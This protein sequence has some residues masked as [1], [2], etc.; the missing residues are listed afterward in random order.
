[1]TVAEV[2]QSHGERCYVVFSDGSIVKT[3]LNVILE[4]HVK[5]G[6]VLADDD[7]SRFVSAST[8]ARCKLRALRIIGTR[9]MSVKELR[10]RLADKGETAENAEAC[11][12]WLQD[13]GYLD[14]GKYAGMVV[15]HYAAKGYGRAKI[16]NE[17][18]RR[19]IPREMWDAALCELPEQDETID[20][21][22]RARL[23]G[24]SPDRQAIKK[25]SDALLRRGFSWEEIKSALYRYQSETD[26]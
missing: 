24:T 9:P 20:R 5:S 18:F 1:M 26:D 19:G 25:A 15:R 12:L 7:Y 6:A 14:D 3:T 10:D 8:L 11:T 22:L 17:L 16:K 13:M 2:R 4:F 23:R 21:L